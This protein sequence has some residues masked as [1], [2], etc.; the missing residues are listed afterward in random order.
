M[1]SLEFLVTSLIVV[2]S[3]GVGVVYTIAAGLGRGGR[4]SVVAALACTLGILP[5]LAAAM[6][7]LAALL[8]ASALAF[9]AVKY[10]GVAYLL[11]M[12]WRTLGEKGALSVEGDRRVR[13]DLATIVEGIAVNLLNPKLTLFFVAFLPQFMA[14]D[15]A[16]P[17]VVMSVLGGVFMAETFVVFAVYGLFAAAFRDR[18]LTRPAVLQWMRRTFAAAFVALGAKLAL[19][20]R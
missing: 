7:G 20:E 16:R 8:H 5:H 12:A 11:W 13:G 17:L 15:E 19:A 18:V 10:A 1:F 2:A 3:P 4:A 14:P 9:T 6:L